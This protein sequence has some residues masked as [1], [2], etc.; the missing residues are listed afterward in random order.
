MEKVKYLFEDFLSEVGADDREFVC[1][2]HESLLHDVYRIKIEFKASGFF[3]SYSHPQTKRSLVNFL[4]RKGGLFVRIYADHIGKYAGFLNLLPEKMEK[5]INK[6]P[7]CKRLIDPADCNPKCITGYDF[8]IRDSRYQ[9]CR[10]CC[11]QFAV[12]PESIPVL[13]EFIENERRKRC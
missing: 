12:N 1:K 11:F 9:R 2:I 5:E 10:Y 3:V 8:L 7:V 13:S 6:A 4:F